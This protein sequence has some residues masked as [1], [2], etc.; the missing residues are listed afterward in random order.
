MAQRK[1]GIVMYGRIWTPVRLQ[2]LTLAWMG[3]LQLLSYI[4]LFV[5][6]I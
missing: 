4:R 5:Q 3:V 6:R 2:R 1:S